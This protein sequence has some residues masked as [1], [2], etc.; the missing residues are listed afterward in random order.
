MKNWKYA[1]VTL[2]VALCTMVTPATAADVTDHG[3]GPIDTS[4]TVAGI[5]GL[6]A[7]GD[8]V[9]PGAERQR[10]PTTD[11]SYVTIAGILHPA[12]KCASPR[13]TPGVVLI[14]TAAKSSPCGS[15]QRPPINT[16]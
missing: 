15:L 10:A 9:S 7:L 16:G 8:S 5:T 2:A 1:L 13:S 11:E 4:Y 3:A 6:P 14:K 12:S